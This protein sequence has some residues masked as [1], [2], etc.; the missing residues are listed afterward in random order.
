MDIATWNIN[1]VKARLETAV[2]WLKEASPDVA[3]L[4]EIK[5]ED[6]PFPREPFEAL[7]IM[8]KRMGKKDSTALRFSPRRRSAM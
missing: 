4:Q 5:S 3:C 6:A 2:A 8:S 7:A 1:G